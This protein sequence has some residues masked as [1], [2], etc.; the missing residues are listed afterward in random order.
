MDFDGYRGPKKSWPTPIPSV[1]LHG[2][3]E[4]AWDV[5]ATSPHRDGH[6]V[7]G[8]TPGRRWP[9]RSRAAGKLAL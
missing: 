9:R 1:G 4:R 2:P 7:R 3:S 8:S 5:R 6:S